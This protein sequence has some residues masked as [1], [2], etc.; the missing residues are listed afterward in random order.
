MYKTWVWW[1]AMVCLYNIRWYVI[2]TYPNT[3]MESLVMSCPLQSHFPSQICHCLRSKS[4]GF[5]TFTHSLTTTI[6]IAI[7]IFATLIYTYYSYLFLWFSARICAF[8]NNWAPWEHGCIMIYLSSANPWLGG[9]CI[10]NAVTACS[11]VVN[12][13]A[14]CQN[15]E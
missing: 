9:F 11:A 8:S 14:Q 2:L 5:G 15:I 10:G 7:L 1:F 12:V 6:I 3:P 4:G 13:W